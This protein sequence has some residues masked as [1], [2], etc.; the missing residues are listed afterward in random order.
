MWTQ[1][2]K[3]KP[4]EDGWYVC[5]IE[6]PNQQRYVMMLYWYGN[7]E[8]GKFIDNLRQ[9]IFDWY[10]VYGYQGEKLKTCSLCDRTDEV[11]AFRKR[12]KSY[13][14]GFKKK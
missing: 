3:H 13:M 14:K 4:K 12:P 10:D 1:F 9:S 6:V 5:T 7:Q 11:V 2:P 8:G